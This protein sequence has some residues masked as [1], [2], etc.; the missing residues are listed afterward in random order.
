LLAKQ[1][2]RNTVLTTP[3]DAH[4]MLIE[5][6]KERREGPKTESGGDVDL[7]HAEW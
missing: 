7:I 6:E 3:T 2:T 5:R 4:K 1:N